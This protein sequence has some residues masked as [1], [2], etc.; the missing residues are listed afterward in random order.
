[1]LCN[2]IQIINEN[3]DFLDKKKLKGKEG[4]IKTVK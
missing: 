4:L 3:S 2:G 1:V